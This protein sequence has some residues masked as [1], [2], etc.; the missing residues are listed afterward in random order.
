MHFFLLPI[1]GETN[2]FRYLISVYYSS[3][4][5]MQTNGHMP[6]KYVQINFSEDIAGNED[7][8]E[9]SDNFE[10]QPDWTTD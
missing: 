1:S 9:N 4:T 2:I 10:F 5:C 6:L 3:I 7:M 8:H